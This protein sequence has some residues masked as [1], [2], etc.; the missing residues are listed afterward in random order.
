[1]TWANG[2]KGLGGRVRVF[3]ADDHAVLRDGLRRLLDDSGDLACVGACGDG[4][5]VL[6]R[7]ATESWDVLVL[8]L[9][10]PTRGGVDVLRQLREGKP[11]LPI[12]ILSA[13]PEEQYALRMLK[14][15]ASGYV[16]KGRPTAE[17]LEAI[18]RCARGGRYL[19][20]EVADQAVVMRHRSGLQPHELLSEREHQIFVLLAT[21]RTPS[22][23]A[24]ELNLSAST[25]STHIGRIKEKL[26]VTSNG[27]IIQY[28]FRLGLIS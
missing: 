16:A 18:R 13:Y 17:L 6:Q 20:E 21:G 14:A 1:M 19:S 27:E 12:V 23:I 3:V 26:S 8:D 9:S 22:Q 4:E 25:V 15:G 11:E 5:E 10:L 28:A 2:Q 24:R 7:A